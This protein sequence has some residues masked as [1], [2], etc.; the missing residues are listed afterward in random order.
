MSHPFDK[1][2]FHGGAKVGGYAGS[3]YRDFPVHWNTFDY[4]RK[5]EPTS[6]IEL[7]CGRGYVLKRLRDYLDIPVRGLEISEHCWLT[8]A[9]SE[10][11]TCDITKAW[12]NGG[13]FSDRNATISA[14]ASPC[15]NTFPRT[16]SR[17]SS[18][19]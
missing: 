1:D 18:N 19:R 12:S 11:V 5:L 16:N 7:G 9:I 8:R 15:S 17:P 3:G 4:V 6:V 13:V 2:Y 10:V 14:S